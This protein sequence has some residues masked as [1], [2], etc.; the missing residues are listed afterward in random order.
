MDEVEDGAPLDI[1]EPFEATKRERRGIGVHDGV[2]AVDDDR[3]RAQLDQT[4]VALLAVGGLAH[5][6]QRH[7]N[8]DE[9]QGAAAHGEDDPAQ[10]HAYEEVVE[11]RHQD[12]VDEQEQGDDDADQQAGALQRKVQPRK[13]GL[14]RIGRAGLLLQ[15]HLACH[16]ELAR[17]LSRSSPRFL[18]P[19]GMTKG[20]DEC[21]LLVLAIDA[22]EHVAHLAQGGVR[23]HAVHD[24]GH[25]VV[26]S[27]LRSCLHTPQRLGNARMVALAAHPLEPPQMPLRALGRDRMNR[28]LDFIL[29]ALGEIVDPDQDALLRIHFLLVAVRRIGVLSLREAF[30]NSLEH[31]AHLVDAREVVEAAALHAVGHGL[32][33]V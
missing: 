2:V 28:D 11:H 33:G 23:A 8:K 24:R 26:A 6:P 21:R 5:C 4:T 29:V 16:P 20:S 32:D 25:H 31:A 22:A 1:L 13:H 19:L 18:A 15:W 12:Q 14:W 17:D 7:A 10:R 30:F 9:Q 3:V 27:G